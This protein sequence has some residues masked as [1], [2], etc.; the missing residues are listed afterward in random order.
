MC[1][2]DPP[3]RPCYQL[4][5]G[6]RGL[7]NEKYAMT[8]ACLDRK[9]VRSAIWRM[10]TTV[11]DHISNCPLERVLTYKNLIYSLNLLFW[12]DTNNKKICYHLIP[13]STTL[14]F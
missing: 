6:L 14:D 5:K 13:S 1:T 11:T 4:T 12:Q 8:S 2:K 9:E 10:Y 7:D 3:N